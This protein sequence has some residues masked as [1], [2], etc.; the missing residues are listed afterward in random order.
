MSTNEI[1]LKLT[2]DK[3][4][5]TATPAPMVWTTSGLSRILNNIA[6]VGHSLYGKT[7]AAK[8]KRNEK[9]KNHENIYRSADF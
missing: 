1:V 9:K 7:K 4:V 6:Y 8:N 2:V 5:T 3:V